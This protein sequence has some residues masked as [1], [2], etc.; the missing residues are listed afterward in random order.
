MEDLDS[1]RLALHMDGAQMLDSDIR[2]VLKDDL[3]A[4]HADAVCLTSFPSA[5]KGERILQQLTLLSGDTKSRVSETHSIGSRSRFNNTIA[6][7]IIA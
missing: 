3:R 5:G 6:S 1:A 4:A 2:P 7:S